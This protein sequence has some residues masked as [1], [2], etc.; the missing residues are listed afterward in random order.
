MALPV[1][2]K[3]WARPGGKRGIEGRPQFQ[4]RAAGKVE[5]R[6]GLEVSVSRWGCSLPTPAPLGVIR[7]QGTASDRSQ[8][9]MGI[10]C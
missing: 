6:W 1:D 9:L 7:A 10:G 8:R 3:A 2:D 5:R 4:P